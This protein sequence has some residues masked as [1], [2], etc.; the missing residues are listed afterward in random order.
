MRDYATT[1]PV[2]TTT[3]RLQIDVW[4]STYAQAK[5]IDHAVRSSLECYSGTLPDGTHVDTIT[6]DS[7]ADLYEE[8][9]RYYRVSSDYLILASL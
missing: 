3:I 5:Q 4:A 1:G 2:A 9:A 6:L 7:S 8:T